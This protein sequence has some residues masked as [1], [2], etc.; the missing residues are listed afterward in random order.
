MKNCEICNEQFVPKSS[1]QKF[2]CKKCQVDYW[3]T[4]NKEKKWNYKAPSVGIIKCK[5]CGDNFKPKINH[6]RYVYCSDKCRDNNPIGK[7]YRKQWKENNPERCL[8]SSRRTNAKR[9]KRMRE[10]SVYREKINKRNRERLVFRKE[11]EPGFREKTIEKNKQWHIKFVEKNGKHYNTMQRQLQKKN[12]PEKYKAWR[13]KC[14]EGKKRK[15]AENP[16]LYKLKQSLRGKAWYHSNKE[17][18]K[19]AIKRYRDNL[20]E[21]VTAEW[22]RQWR[23]NNPEKELAKRQRYLERHPGISAM[24]TAAYRAQKIKA[25]PK[26]LT[27][28]HY[29]QI[30]EIYATCP[31]DCDVDHVVPLRNPTVSGLHVPWNLE[32]MKKLDNMSKGNRLGKKYEEQ[33]KKSKKRWGFSDGGLV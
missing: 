19:A 1:R 2:C 20:P 32:H 3:R 6:P 11:S 5:T 9:T 26:W 10:D 23:K 22:Q 12:D 28:E 30:A 24:H 15:E 21:G 13:Q 27:E 16:E 25:T 14:E 33:L 18:R 7:E 29:K 4:K 17:K 8:A 31:K